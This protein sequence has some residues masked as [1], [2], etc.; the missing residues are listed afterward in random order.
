MLE[1]NHKDYGSGPAVII[2]HGLFGTL[3]NWQ[4]IARML[5]EH[6][7]VFILDQ[8]N[9]GRSPH[10]DVMNY[11][12]MAEDLRLFM[13][14]HGIYEAHIIGHSMGGKVAMQFALYYPDFVKKLV[15][16]DIVPK[17]YAGGHEDI[18]KALMGLDLAVMKTRDEVQTYLMAK[19]EGDLSEVLFLMKDLTRTPEGSFEWKMNLPVLNANYPTL[20]DAVYGADF[21][22][23][24]LFVRGS[25]SHYVQDSDMP[26]ILE[27]FPEAELDTIEGAGHWIHADKPHELLEVLMRFL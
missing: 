3:D 6:F 14:T 18:F 17:K 21:M 4:T 27:L 20:M 15:V 12:A 26:L 24:T 11:E 22:G 19:L 7:T 25:K 8:R 16:L 23:P 9:H 5:G 1:L 10:S 2:L 13:E